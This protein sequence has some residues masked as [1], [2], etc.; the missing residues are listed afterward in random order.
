MYPVAADL[1]DGDALPDGDEVT[2]YCKP[3]AYDLE[4]SQPTFLAFMKRSTENDLSIN[5][6]H[7]FRG[8]DRAGAVDCIRSEVRSH[9]EL[10]PHGRFV[11][12]NVTGAKSAAQKKGF[13]IGIIYTP[14]RSSPS[15]S[16]IVD[17]PTDYDAEIRVATAFLRLITQADI[18]PAVP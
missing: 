3:S 15:H 6:L 17:L 8:H 13:D 7:S 10:K 18:Y 14:R 4:R 1:V 12:F 16:S 11:V 9:Y 2:R 5:R